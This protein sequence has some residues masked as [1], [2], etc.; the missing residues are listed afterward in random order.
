MKVILLL[1]SVLFILSAVDNRKNLEMIFTYK[2]SQN[3]ALETV[4]IREGVSVTFLLETQLSTGYDWELEKPVSAIVEVIDDSVSG[5]EPDLTVMG[6]SEN[7]L[8]KFRAVKKGNAILTF[9]YKRSWE[10]NMDP[11]KILKIKV[12]VN[13]VK[14]RSP[15]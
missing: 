8:F 9:L 7:H 15:E 14:V 4:A 11:L 13:E 12:V 1:L 2:L 5:K 6:G 3:S 10:K